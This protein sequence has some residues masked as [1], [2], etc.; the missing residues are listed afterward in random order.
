MT[1][2][3]RKKNFLAVSLTVYPVYRVKFIY[4]PTYTKL[5][6]YMRHFVGNRQFDDKKKCL[7][8]TIE[9]GKAIRVRKS[10][11]TRRII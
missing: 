1:W 3:L 8:L 2:T 4:G 9:T 6:Q 10:L 7:N 5:T 11:K